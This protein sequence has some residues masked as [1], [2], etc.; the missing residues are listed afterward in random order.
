MGKNGDVRQIVKSRKQPQ[1]WIDRISKHEISCIKITGDNLLFTGESRRVRLW[2]IRASGSKA[3]TTFDPEADKEEKKF[4]HPN[5][6]SIPP[7]QANATTAK[8]IRYQES[9]EFLV[10]SFTSL[11]GIASF[12]IRGPKHIVDIYDYHYYPVTAFDTGRHF[13]EHIAISAGTT[14]ILQYDLRVI[15]LTQPKDSN[16][17][18]DIGFGNQ[19]VITR[20]MMVELRNA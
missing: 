10:A 14:Q 9:F 4:I 3:Q 13:N 20:L 16:P 2:D 8:A 7:K 1:G 12:D 15:D 19:A 18:I 6:F 5:L 17:Q 11:N